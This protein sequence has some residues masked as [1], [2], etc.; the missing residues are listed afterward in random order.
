M[1]VSPAERRVESLRRVSRART[2]IIITIATQFLFSSYIRTQY[3]IS[4]F[5]H[6]IFATIP[7][8]LGDNH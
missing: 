6:S 5:N 3:R 7:R 2:I 4:E 1:I 8:Q